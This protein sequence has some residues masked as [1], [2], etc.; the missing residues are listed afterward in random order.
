MTIKQL[1]PGVYAIPLGPV[2]AYLIDDSDPSPDSGQSLTLIDT[3]IP[4]SAEQIMQAVRELGRQPA[5]IRHI[6]VTHCHPDHSGSLAALKAATGAD[7]YMHA[8][9]AA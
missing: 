4:G 6:L 9:D 7:T 8:E 3:G 5:D 2:N 1:V